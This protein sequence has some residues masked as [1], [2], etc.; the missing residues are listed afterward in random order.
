MSPDDDPLAREV[1]AVRTAL[2]AWLRDDHTF[3]RITGADAAS[4]LHSQT[5]NDV[6]ALKS[7]EGHHNA[8]L[9][10]QGRLQAHFTLHRWADEFWMLVE[11]AQWAHLQEHLDAHLFIEDAKMEETGGDLDQIVIQGPETL[12]VLARIL[13]TD[14][15]AT[16]EL[17]PNALHGVHPIELSNIETLAFRASPTGEDGY[18]LVLEKGKGR[19]FL[20]EVLSRACELGHE[21][22]EISPD[23]REVL[24]IEAGL[25]RLGIDIDRGQVI[26][27]TSLDRDCVSYT[28]GCYL[29]Q[30]V[31]ARLKTYGSPKRAL[32]GIVNRHNNPQSTPRSIGLRPME[33]EPAARADPRGTLGSISIGRRPM[34]RG[35]T[36]N[37]P[38]TSIPV[39]DYGE[40]DYNLLEDP[41]GPI[42]IR[43]GANLPH[44][45]RENATYF[46]TFRLAGS[47]PRAVLDALREGGRLR[48]KRLDE[49]LDAGNGPKHLSVPEIATL[50]QDALL[51]FHGQRYFL[52]AWSIMPNHV[53][54]VFKPFPGHELSE[55]LRSWKNYTARFANKILGT[56][57]QFWQKETYDHLIRD[58]REFGRLLAYTYDN[59]DKAGLKNWGWRGYHDPEL[60]IAK[61]SG[62]KADD[63]ITLHRPEA[64]ATGGELF[65]DDKTIGRVS[66]RCISPTLNAHI[67][68]AS[69]D[70]D[71]RAPGTLLDTGGAQAEVQALP[72]YEAPSREDRSRTLYDRALQLFQDDTDDVDPAAIPLLETALLLHPRF[73]DAYEVLG[74]ILHRQGRTDDAIGVMLQLAEINPECF[75][76]HT[77]L[78]VFYV[79]KGLIPEAEEEK[80]KAAVVQMHRAGAERA[81]RD[82]ADSERR[83]LEEEA[84]E[85]I[86]MFLEV[87][88][89]DPDDPLA[90]F[91]LGKAY[92]Q[93]NQFADALP[94]LERATQL[95]KDFSAAWLDYAKCH[96][97]LGHAAEAAAAYKA[98]IAA[99]ARKRDLMPMRE[100]ERRLKAL[101]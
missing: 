65:S 50:V 67:A 89:I 97:F 23:A 101:A 83:R 33:N 55:I 66:S 13:G 76:A 47:L 90:T 43:Y 3:V 98:G 100:M 12:A 81:A 36:K 26:S 44:W 30:E 82:A 68:L 54:A 19:A 60:K 92:I 10:R 32:M 69:L 80:A 15:V 91:G 39:A 42:Q 56:A 20:D 63:G 9:D 18:V 84:R 93:L 64:D 4:W 71:H 1:R 78:S 25:P 52:F 86:G 27:E 62:E 75:M 14:H 70:R 53:H 94:H 7:G 58:A 41:T 79:A 35:A 74:V 73:E 96:E 72:F 34:L 5:T 85:R 40:V 16:N 77:N 17:L 49:E 99:A 11:R 57:G 24:R 59:P 87:L 51:H 21:A 2:G 38:E 22:L 46:V 45:T 29:G 95:Q 6:L 48:F 88:E 31:V 28:K 8:A 37:E 61:R